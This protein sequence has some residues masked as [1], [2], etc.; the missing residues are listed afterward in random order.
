MKGDHGLSRAATF[1]E[2]IIAS[3][4]SVSFS[5]LLVWMSGSN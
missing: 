4:V 2:Q 1:N 3:V 5:L